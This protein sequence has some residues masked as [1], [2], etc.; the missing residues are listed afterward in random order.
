MVYGTPAWHEDQT[1][2]A[3]I[4][5]NVIFLIIFI[6]DI[7]VQLNT[8]YI[9][10]S[11][12]ILDRRRVRQR[13]THYYIYLDILQI[14]IFFCSI[15]ARN[16]GLMY[17]KLVIVLKFMRM[18]EFDEIIIRK[19]S[20]DVA[21]KTIYIISKQLVTVFVLSHTIG[22]LFYLFDYN[23]LDQP[24]CAGSNSSCTTVR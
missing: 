8:G 14:I 20:T 13:Y 22:I 24:V 18:F 9:T 12:V 23:L 5:L 3:I 21:L 4:A 17:A 15:V 10:N 7:Y 11:A 16:L 2:P 1:S 6:A 19:F